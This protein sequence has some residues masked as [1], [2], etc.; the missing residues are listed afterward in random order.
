M[1]YEYVTL[2]GYLRRHPR[3]SMILI[4]IGDHQPPA[5]VSG[6]DASRSV[7]VHVFGRRGPILGR[8]IERGFRPGLAPHRPPIGP[9]HALTPIFLEAFSA[10]PAVSTTRYPPQTTRLASPR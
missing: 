3:D 5:A 4:A 1:A 8:L 9:M 6:R 2:A 7:P 10:A